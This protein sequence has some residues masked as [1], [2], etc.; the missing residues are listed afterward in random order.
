MPDQPLTGRCIVCRYLWLVGII[1][2]AFSVGAFVQASLPS[3]QP[4]AAG[5]QPECRTGSEHPIAPVATSTS[6]QHSTAIPTSQPQCATPEPAVQKSTPRQDNPCPSGYSRVSGD[7]RFFGCPSGYEIVD[8]LCRRPPKQ[9]TYARYCGGDDRNGD[10]VGDDVSQRD[11]SCKETTVTA[12]CQYGCQAG[13][14]RPAP[15]GTGEITVTPSRV[16]PGET[17]KVSWT[18]NY[19]K[20]DSCRVR[21]LSQYIHDTGTGTEGSF[22]SSPIPDTI[23]YELSC[24]ELSGAVFTKTTIVTVGL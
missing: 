15:S 6:D 3:S 4:L 8:G 1:A 5:Q 12:A 20:P 18:T 23:P 10:G 2:L 17:V 9:C 7:C 16:H 24:F 19:M 11:I 14:C 22:T 13:A 21:S